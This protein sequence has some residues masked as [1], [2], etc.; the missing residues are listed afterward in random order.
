MMPKRKRNLFNLVLESRTLLFIP[1]LNSTLV[2]L[3]VYDCF[4]Y[5]VLTKCDFLTPAV[6]SKSKNANSTYLCLLFLLLFFQL[7]IHCFHVSVLDYMRRW[8][9]E[10]LLLKSKVL[11][12]VLNLYVDLNFSKAKSEE[13]ERGWE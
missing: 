12:N 7:T 4:F 5:C 13:G 8:R 2:P 6:K 1:L 9:L 3:A 10:I 11:V